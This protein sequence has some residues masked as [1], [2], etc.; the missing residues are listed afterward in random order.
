MHLPYI[1]VLIEGP[2]D[3]TPLTLHADARGEFVLPD[4]FDAAHV[5][6]HGLRTPFLRIIA[7]PGFEVSYRGPAA[8]GPHVLNDPPAPQVTAQINVLRHV[9][10]ARAFVE[11]YDPA[12][13]V[14]ARSFIARVGVGDLSC[15]AVYGGGVFEFGAAG[16]ACPDMAYSTVIHHEFAHALID[17]LYGTPP[18]SALEEGLAD[19]FTVLMNGDPRIAT[20]PPGTGLGRDVSAG[21]HRWPDDAGGDP[22]RTGLIVAGAWWDL[23]EELIAAHGDAGQERVCALFFETL[24][25]FPMAVGPELGRLV[26]LA[27]AGGE[28]LANGTP[29][30]SAVVRTFGRRGLLPPPWTSTILQVDPVPDMP[31]GARPRVRVTVEGLDLAGPPVL[32]ASRNGAPWCDVP[33]T[34]AAAAV[35]TAALPALDAPGL[36]TYHV[37][38]RNRDHLQ[39]VA[40]HGAPRDRMYFAVGARRVLFA[41]DFEDGGDRWRHGA[42]R[43][44]DPWRIGEAAAPAS[45]WG[46]PAARSGSR[47]AGMGLDGAHDANHYPLQSFSFLRSPPIRGTPGIRTVLRF[48]RWLTVAGG[49]AAWI[50]A[51]GMRVW[52]SEGRQVVDSAWTDAAVDITDAISGDGVFTVAFLLEAGSHGRPMGGWYVDDVRIET[53]TDET[54]FIR[55]DCDGSGTLRIDDVLCVLKILAGLAHT[56]CPAAADVDADGRITIADALRLLRYLFAGDAP[57]PAPFPSAGEDSTPGALACGEAPDAARC[58]SYQVFHAR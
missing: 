12:H 39:A 33:F 18:E 40:P 28:S 30:L 13:P 2:A 57:P 50:E 20:G 5:A 45:F 35:Y 36:V 17:S 48:S 58:P 54:V 37:T 38:A 51:G 56:R 44:P 1:E 24:R 41:D 23:R 26:L 25:C 55:G 10:A 8:G 29:H 46:P 16:I 42:Y 11:A 32:H 3:G 47:C 49:H 7:P 53:L 19:S 22:Y 4:G 21:C 9:A 43:G 27:D 6:V 15:S 52:E 14:L 34:R 31:V